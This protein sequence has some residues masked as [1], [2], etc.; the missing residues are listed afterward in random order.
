MPNAV[1]ARPI[2]PPS[3][4][5]PITQSR[6]A[7]A[8][9][10]TPNAADA[11]D[12]MPGTQG[13][14]PAAGVVPGLKQSP[15]GA[16]FA[17]RGAAVQGVDQQAGAA[18]KTAP[19]P[20]V[21]GSTSE[22]DQTSG[23]TARRISFP[24][25]AVVQAWAVPG[26]TVR[27]YNAS[28]LATGAPQLLKA[29]VVPMQPALN[30]PQ[31]PTCQSGAYPTQ[32]EF[33][34]AAA[35][36][37]SAEHTGMQLVSVP[38]SPDDDQCGSDTFLVT[39]QTGARAESE[40]RALKLFGYSVPYLPRHP[41]ETTVDTKR[42]A[43][44]GATLTSTAPWATA[45]G[46]SFEALRDGLATGLHAEA[47]DQGELRF[48]LQTLGALDGV[49]I[50]AH[51]VSGPKVIDLSALGLAAGLNQGSRLA[52]RWDHQL[53]SAFLA[54]TIDG[55][56]RC[57]LDGVPDG[58]AVDVTIPSSG[59]AGRFVAQGGALCIDLPGLVQGDL[60]NL[61]TDTT[62]I[63]NQS[64]R[65]VLDLHDM[66]Q[67]DGRSSLRAVPFSLDGSFV[68]PLATDAA[69]TQLVLDTFP[70]A[71]RNEL[72][73][74]LDLFGPYARVK[75]ADAVVDPARLQRIY[76]GAKLGS[77]IPAEWDAAVRA[78]VAKHCDA[79]F[80]EG[81]ALGRA[82]QTA[83]RTSLARLED[84]SARII[85][86]G[87]LGITITGGYSP[88]SGSHGPL[89]PETT[90]SPDTYE[91]TIGDAPPLR[92]TS[93]GY[94]ATGW[95]NPNAIGFT[96]GVNLNGGGAAFDYTLFNGGR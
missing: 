46:T 20:A 81:V 53:L 66:L 68:I 89:R 10:A 42:L 86:R 61:A 54:P 50:V 57:T 90:R 9:A 37:M 6:P 14:L 84:V 92:L 69:R 56:V 17:L 51:G 76:E 87:E 47:D 32:R 19:P 44:D 3:A 96:F 71:R 2:A 65:N 36:F 28:L 11:M 45:P 59:F 1:A 85:Q 70:N 23:P 91:L 5:A 64:E 73:Q 77:A 8:A 4:V 24:A 48:D 13:P 75:G 78:H 33:N 67:R 27:I 94:G 22:S 16:Y 31:A 55:H 79:D 29:V 62:A 60:V 83:L 88:I 82:Y 21:I 34:A 30:A 63:P 49:T 74:L 40:P 18:P 95:V 26:S 72:Q 80:V 12:A 93:G 52:A 58:M 39:M 38:M 43:M 15:V 35:T 7:I 25:N 41:R